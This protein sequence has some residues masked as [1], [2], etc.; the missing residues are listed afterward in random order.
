MALS[1][2]HPKDFLSG[3]IFI[4][5]GLGFLYIAQDYRM[6]TATRMGPGYFPSILAG[7]LTLIGLTTSLR[8]LFR[9]GEKVEGFAWKPLVIVLVGTVLFGVLVRDAGL[10]VALLAYIGIT[11]TAS[12]YFH[13]RPTLMMAV[14]L[15]VFS[16]IIFIKALGLPIPMIG[17]WFGA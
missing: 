12:I 4:A 17:A 8:A 10:I 3:V 13:W 5:L 2:R 7:I 14:G 6:G 9:D 15:T 1:I 11:A 16:V